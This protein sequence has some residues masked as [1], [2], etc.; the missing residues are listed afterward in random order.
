M[1][2]EMN[3]KLN[4]LEAMMVMFEMANHFPSCGFDSLF[5]EDVLRKRKKVRLLIGS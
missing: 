4:T 5:D 3:S 1:L 2:M